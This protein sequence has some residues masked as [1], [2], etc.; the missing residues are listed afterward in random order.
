MG[1]HT[2]SRE[3]ERGEEKQKNLMHTFVAE[4]VDHDDLGQVPAG[5]PLDDAV[6]SPHQGGPARIVED[7]DDAGREQVV[8]VV[9]VLTSDGQ[10]TEGVLLKDY[11]I[12]NEPLVY[13]YVCDIDSTCKNE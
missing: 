11:C 3:K 7:N 1:R 2:P 8:I 5:G 4:I 12:E 9:P 6:Y 13:V 10:R